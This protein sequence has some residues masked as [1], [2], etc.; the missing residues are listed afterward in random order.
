MAVYLDHAA[1]T[2]MR[3]EAVQ[4]WQAVSGL[5]GNASSIHTHGQQA[6]RVLE[7][8]R[9]QLADTLGCEPIEVIFTSGGT[10]AG[11][12]AIAG[13]WHRRGRG[14]IVL[15]DG[16]H[17]ATLDTVQH[18][19]ARGAQVR[20]VPLDELGR[21]DVSAFDAAC[22]GACVATALAAN[23]EVGTVN[24]VEALARTAAD[25]GVPL[26]VDAVAAFGHLPV[27]FSG[28]RGQAPAGAGL[29]AMS[30]SAHKIGGPMGVGALVVHRSAQMQPL[31][32]GGAPQRGL[33]AGTQ[34]VAGAVAFAA[35]A[36][37]AVAEREAEAARLSALRHELVTR[38]C[39]AV[40]GARAL[41]DAEARIP[42]HAHFHFPGADGDAVLFLLDRAG[43][44]VSTGS[45]CQAGVAE[46]SH[47]VQ[48]MGYD[49]RAAREV[50]R[51]TMGRTSTHADVDAFVAAIGP[52]VHTARSARR[53]TG[54]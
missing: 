41:G 18:L 37:A 49:D 7:D 22:A 6:R 14:A 16:E 36:V 20:A 39:A 38:T 40:E 13:T 47:V 44:S 33:R 45:A 12:L 52:A 15:P 9:E 35:A 32:F 19:H 17:H 34:D 21:I 42:G 23:N 28:W 4:A 5:V 51:A 27:S 3:A 48:A 46:P 30:V 10:E 31:L 8:A 29:V 26:H 1:S 43:V 2:P 53:R 11:N 25:A 24:D 54:S 50:I